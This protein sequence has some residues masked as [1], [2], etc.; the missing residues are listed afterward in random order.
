VS[1]NDPTAEYADRLPHRRPPGLRLTTLR[2]SWFR[3]DADPPSRWRWTP[4]ASPGGRFD[5]AAGL[6]RVRYAT[7]SQRGAMRERFDGQGRVV[8]ASE[9]EACLVEIIGTVRVLD[10]RK[11]RT[12]DALG[13]DDQINTSRAPGPWLACHRLTDRVLDWFDGSV[14]GIVYRSRTTPERGANLALL[15]PGAIRA[16][17]LGRLGTRRPLLIACITGDGFAVDGVDL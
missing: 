16:R 17:S 12:I 15:R 3:I 10:L 1:L 8:S 6:V 7:D 11:D 9:A 4:F 2:R 13:L 14:D 5:W